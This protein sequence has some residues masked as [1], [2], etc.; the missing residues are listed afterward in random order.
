MSSYPST[1]TSADLPLK[2][3]N[4]YDLDHLAG[5]INAAVDQG[6]HDL[7]KLADGDDVRILDTIP[8][9]PI[10]T[11]PLAGLK[12]SDYLRKLALTYSTLSQLEWDPIPR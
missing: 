5:V 3:Q 11:E 2:T 7:P 1:F 6:T 8:S 10:H 4:A 9:P 12:P